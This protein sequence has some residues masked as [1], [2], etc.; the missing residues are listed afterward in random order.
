MQGRNAYMHRYRANMP[1]EQRERYAKIRQNKDRSKEYRN[2]AIYADRILAQV[3]DDDFQEFPVDN[4][5]VE[6]A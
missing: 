5:C 4:I 2:P 3:N 6:S 1:P